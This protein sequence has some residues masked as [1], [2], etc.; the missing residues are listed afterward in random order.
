[1]PGLVGHVLCQSYKF[2]RPSRGNER[3][4]LRAGHVS[5]GS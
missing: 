4:K 5:Y 2:S 3:R 1:V